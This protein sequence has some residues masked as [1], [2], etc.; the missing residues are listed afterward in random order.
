MKPHICVIEDDISLANSIKK[1]LELEGFNVTNLHNGK[2]GYL[3][4]L[5]NYRFVDAV[6]LD[7]NLPGMNGLDI[8][9]DIRQKAIDIPILML[10]N[11]LRT[12][13]VVDAFDIG[14]DD[15][16]KKPFEIKELKARIDLRLRKNYQRGERIIK[17]RDLEINISRREAKYKGRLLNLRRKEF[18]LLIFLLRNRGQAIAR[19]EI[20]SCVW[21]FDQMPYPNTIDAHISVIRKEID[22]KDQ[23]IIKTI[24]GIGYKFVD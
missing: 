9:H 19:D 20:I 7:I 24:H 16:I 13:T 3:Y 22:D 18:D 12:A 6:I 1:F 15:Y 23:N 21:N 17:H 2:E 11:E 8:C 5:D 14:A 4:L 10:T